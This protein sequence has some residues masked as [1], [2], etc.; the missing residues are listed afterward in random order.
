M[1]KS[2]LIIDTPTY[3]KECP[4]FHNFDSWFC[5]AHYKKYNIARKFTEEECS[6]DS[7][8]NWCPLRPVPERRDECDTYYNSDYYRSHQNRCFC[9][10]SD[11]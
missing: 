3:C 2:L 11:T 9:F 6:R 1:S 4:F 10:R 8:P 7:V 5:S